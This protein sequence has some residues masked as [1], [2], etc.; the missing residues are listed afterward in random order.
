MVL[1]DVGSSRSESLTQVAG[2]GEREFSPNPRDVAVETLPRS[3]EEARL[4]NPKS[5]GLKTEC[6]AAN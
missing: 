1:E 6:V 3:E 4:E 5:V 2:A